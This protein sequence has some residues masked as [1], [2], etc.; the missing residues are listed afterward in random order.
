MENDSGIL[1]RPLDNEQLVE[2]D[3]TLLSKDSAVTKAENDEP[4]TKRIKTKEPLQSE[5]VKGVVPVKQE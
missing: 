2:A 5:K 1:K 4:P 3:S